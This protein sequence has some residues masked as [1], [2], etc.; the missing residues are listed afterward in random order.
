M[1][2]AQNRAMPDQIAGNRMEVDAFERADEHQN[3]RELVDVDRTS[4]VGRV[5]MQSSVAPSRIKLPV[6]Y[7][8]FRSAIHT[9]ALNIEEG[10]IGWMKRYG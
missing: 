8:P 5:S 7:C 3:E 6:L 10:T 4:T 9:D 1:K 2:F